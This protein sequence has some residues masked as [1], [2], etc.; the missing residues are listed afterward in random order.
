MNPVE[1]VYTASTKLRSP[2][3]LLEPFARLMPVMLCQ[4]CQETP[5]EYGG[6]LQKLLPTLENSAVNSPYKS[7]SNVTVSIRLAFIYVSCTQIALYITFLL[8]YEPLSYI[9]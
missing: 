6:V 4:A 1:E 7:Q 8:I 3:S 9:L 5:P 2:R